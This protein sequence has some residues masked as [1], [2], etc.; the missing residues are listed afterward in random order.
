MFIPLRVAFLAFALSAAPAWAK[1]RDRSPSSRGLENLIFLAQKEPTLT[2]ALLS[3]S[4]ALKG[5]PYLIG[6]SG[7]G[8]RGLYDQDPLWRL[9]VMDCTTYIETVMAVALSFDRDSFLRHLA[10]IRYENARVTYQARNHFPE[11]DWLPNNKRAG[12]VRDLTARLFPQFVRVS[13]VTIRKDLWYGQKTAND[14]EPRTREPWEREQRAAELRA[15]A[16]QFLPEAAA[17]PYLPMQAMYR[18]GTLEPNT[19]VLR[20][21]PTGALFHIVREGWSPGGVPMA[22]SHQGFLVQKPDGT[23][24][25]HA[26]LNRGVVEERIDLYFQKFLDSPTVRG[27]QVLMVRDPSGRR[28]HHIQ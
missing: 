7:E 17:I 3:V 8:E 21:I 4:G 20:K 19:E 23:Y 14:I 25:R 6:N 26:A 9:D 12:F 28:A 22:V 24:M 5:T 27:V 15:M 16:H 2:G 1:N 10:E 18:P 13:K 11:T